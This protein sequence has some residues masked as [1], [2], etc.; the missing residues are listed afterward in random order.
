MIR[1]PPR[2]TLFPY[3]T[4][5]RSQQEVGPHVGG[6][7]LVQR[8][9]LDVVQLEVGVLDDGHDAPPPSPQTCSGGSGGSGFGAARYG[10]VREAGLVARSTPSRMTGPL[11]ALT[12]T[13]NSVSITSSF[14]AR[15]P[16]VSCAFPAR[17][18][19]SISRNEPCSA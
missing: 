9:D 15:P 12:S 14:S 7:A 13:V 17:A 11:P 10:K 16:Q 6:G 5:F 19:S 2:S 1:R 8:P 3:T 4:L 18:A